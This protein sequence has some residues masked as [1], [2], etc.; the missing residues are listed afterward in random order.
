MGGVRSFHLG[1]VAAVLAL[2]GAALA[3][4]PG[5]VKA[6]AADLKK[7][8]AAQNGEQIQRALEGLLEAGGANACD[9]VVSILPK[10]ARAG[11]AVYW[12]LVSAGAGF[13]DG[14]ALTFLGEFMLKNKAAPFTRDLLFALENNGSPLTT[15]AL[16][17]VLEKGPYDLQLMAADQLA[18][19]RTVA[20]VD[21]LIAQLK[22]EGDKGDPELKRRVLTALQA[23]TGESMGDAV[24]WTGWWDANRANG[25]PERREARSSGGA[26][27]AS[28]TLDPNRQRDFES[29][30]RN[31]SRIIVISSRLPA[32]DPKEPNADYNYDHMESIL[33]EMDIAHTVVLKKEFEKEPD[34][35]LR[36]AWTVLV[37]CNNIQTQCICGD[38]RRILQQKVQQGAAGGVKNRLYGCPPECSKHDQVSHRMSKQTIDRLK[39]WVEAGGYLFTEDWGIVE[40]LQPA[41][42]DKV[43]NGRIT[44][45]G[46]GG[47]GGGQEFNLVRAM[48]VTITPGRGLTSLPRL[49]GVF[50]RPRPPAEERP[51]GED[52]DGTRTRD[53]GAPSRP[54]RR[55]TS[56][57]STT[58]RSS[59]QGRGI[60]RCSWS[61]DLA[62]TVGDGNGARSRSRSAWATARPAAGRGRASRRQAADRRR[63]QRRRRRCGPL[64]RARRVGRGAAQ[65][66]RPA[67][68]QPLRQAAVAARTRSSCRTS[69]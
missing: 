30:Q 41:W 56:G 5:D 10:L 52:G 62:A 11:D 23:I 69:S 32:D 37:N 40:I 35:Y 34:K 31:P 13:R 39:A 12:Q 38:C 29:L 4:P 66:A 3:A 22:K 53:P 61:A 51:A 57:R 1:P 43:E 24:N 2:A 63:E 19:V 67:L 17:P 45:Q 36:D 50:Q 9:E 28:Q 46:A 14:P 33:R 16:A 44:P 60:P 18:R 42:P 25:L 68:H 8:V 27:L 65:R 7:G 59:D 21:A 15:N 20:A 55:S 58:R 6:L 47:G 49:R 64:A 54:R 48:D 26:A